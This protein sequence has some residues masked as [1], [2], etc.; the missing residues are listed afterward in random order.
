MF[1]IL[2]VISFV[3][4]SSWPWKSPLTMHA[5]IFPVALV[6]SSIFPS[7]H[8]LS[9]SLALLKLANKCITITI[10]KFTVT[11]LLIELIAALE[12]SPVLPWLFASSMALVVL[13][14]TLVAP[15]THWIVLPV[16]MGL[17]I[18]PLPAV[19]VAIRVHQLTTALSLIILEVP[20]IVTTV[21][22]EKFAGSYFLAVLAL[23]KVIAVGIK[24]QQRWMEAQL[25]K[26]KA[27]GLGSNLWLNLSWNSDYFLTMCAGS[28][29]M[30][31]ALLGECCWMICGSQLMFFLI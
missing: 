18:L 24:F 13:P 7:H 4:L 22:E 6:D 20:W 29:V 8:S 23:P 12:S 5:I 21:G 26:R 28:L 15:T 2:E 19:I 30:T 3:K 1:L 11:A 27:V 31:R 9:I 25:R 16:S 10:E 17:I 14:V